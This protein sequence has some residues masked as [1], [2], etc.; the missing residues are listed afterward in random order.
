METS[1]ATRA[2][3]LMLGSLATFCLAT[4][5][6]CATTANWTAS[7]LDVWFYTNASSA[8][9]RALGPT[10][11]GGV[12]VNE[13]TQQFEQHSALDPARLGTTLIAFNTSTQVAAGLAANRYQVNSV[14][15]TATWTYDFDPH[16]LYY[17]D[18]PVS[19]AQILAE[20]ASGNVSSQRPME[21]FGVGLSPNYAGFEFSGATA[22]PPLVDELTHPYTSSGY[23]AYPVVGSATEA[24]AYVDVTNS[25]TGGYS[26]TAPGN[27]TGPFTPAPWAIGKTNQTVG[28]ALPDNTTFTFALDLAAA[29]VQSYVQQSLA[30]GGLGLFLSS[31]HTPG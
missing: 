2:A 13:T 3:V 27:S 18:T 24:G 22:G 19:Q 31:L 26:S 10:F 17:E 30:S 16:T 29:G 4:P 6:A 21:L 23:V 15:L 7:D 20:Y 28:A 14:T 1:F 12:V 8:G 25:V 5:A 9:S 11:L